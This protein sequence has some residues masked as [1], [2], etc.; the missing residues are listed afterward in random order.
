MLNYY[1]GKV[2]THIFDSFSRKGPYESSNVSLVL[3]RKVLAK[4]FMAKEDL[5]PEEEVDPSTFDDPVE[6]GSDA[7]RV[8]RIQKAYCN[9]ENYRRR[10]LAI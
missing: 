1:V 5:W 7:W 9:P 8:Q 10:N 2:R 4:G 3:Y 6:K